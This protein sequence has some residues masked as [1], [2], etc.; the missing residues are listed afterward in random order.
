MTTT[1]TS[2]NKE[3]SDQAFSDLA[4]VIENS[5]R[6]VWSIKNNMCRFC[7]EIKSDVVP[8]STKYRREIMACPECMVQV[9][10]IM[11]SNRFRL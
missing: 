8:H 2:N 7:R 1:T 10:A 3:S 5:I 6:N 11:E 9:Q 4:D